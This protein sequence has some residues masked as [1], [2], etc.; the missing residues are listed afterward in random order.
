MEKLL[1]LYPEE[2]SGKVDLSPVLNHVLSLVDYS[3]AAVKYFIWYHAH[4]VQRPGELLGISWV[5]CSSKQG[6]GK[7]T[8]MDW[9]GRRL[10]G[11]AL[12]TTTARIDTLLG[13]FATGLAS[14]LYVN[15]DEASGGDTFDKS[16]L[17]KNAI[18]AQTLDYEQKGAAIVSIMNFARWLFSSNSASSV[19]VE[20][21]DRRMVCVE[22][23]NKHANDREYFGKL[24]AWM[25][26]DLHVVAFYRYLMSIDLTGYDWAKERPKTE[27]WEDMRRSSVPL[28]AMWAEWYA[29]VQGEESG[30]ENARD[31]FKR[32]TNWATEGRHRCEWSE[33]KFGREVKK[34]GGLEF[35]RGKVSKQYKVDAAKVVAWLKESGYIESSPEFLWDSDDE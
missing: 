30:W 19:K 34:V 5:M 31:V 17:I 20:M 4:I 25:K 13:R 12:Y 33:A 3:E 35:R 15:L 22:A 28:I 1:E 7:N 27:L 11:D 26:E 18:T 32:F 24:L 10:L 8:W 16:N 6:V 23:S 29:G 9:F 14:K 2:E 21:E